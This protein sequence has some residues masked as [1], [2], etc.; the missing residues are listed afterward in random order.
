LKLLQL[1]IS[2]T[3]SPVIGKRFGVQPVLRET[4]HLPRFAQQT[5]G[6]LIL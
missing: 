1:A 2:A 5:A 3:A 6:S 4:M